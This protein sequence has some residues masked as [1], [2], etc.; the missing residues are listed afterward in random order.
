MTTPDTS[1]PTH[2]IASLVGIVITMI[3]L[4]QLL[5]GIGILRGA[6]WGRPIGGMFSLLF[7]ILSLQWAL[8]KRREADDISAFIL[9]SVFVLFAYSAIVLMFRWRRPWTT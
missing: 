4:V 9:G 8:T 2:G 7:G 3:G 1:P 6:E 5:G